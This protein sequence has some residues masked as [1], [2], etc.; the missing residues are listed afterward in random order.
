MKR[1]LIAVCFAAALCAAQTNAGGRPVHNEAERLQ[2]WKRVEVRFDG[3]KLTARE[4]R[5]VLRLTAACRAIDEVYRRQSDTGG[6]V[7]YRVT[8]DP[9][10]KGLLGASYGRWDVLDN[11]RPFI[12]EMPMPRG[13]D[14]YPHQLTRD[15]IEQYVR[16]HPED[17]MAVYS[18]VTV[19]KSRGGRLVGVPY[20]EEFAEWLKPAA[21]A[22]RDAAALSDD[23]TLQSRADGLLRDQYVEDAG[24][25]R[26]GI[27]LGAFG[28]ELDRLL[29][30]KR[31]FEAAVFLR[32]GA[33]VDLIYRGG[34]PGNAT[35]RNFTNALGSTPVFSLGLEA[36]Q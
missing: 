30:V 13:H 16:E 22:L 28:T 7:M 33:G 27:R 10:L 8:R 29:G 35:Y 34:A 18:P 14:L 1:L 12:G 3:S 25:S 36:P 5:V 4:R 19:V 20:H 17:R 26:I 6:A 15:Q 23:G 32:D 11:N 31:A 21:Q 24:S 2:R 9:A